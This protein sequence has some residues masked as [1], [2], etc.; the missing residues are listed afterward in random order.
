MSADN[1]QCSVCDKYY[2][3]VGERRGRAGHDD[4]TCAMCSERLATIALD[5]IGD[6]ELAKV[7]RWQIDYL[8]LALANERKERDADNLYAQRGY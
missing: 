1:W 8:R 6:Q 5:C 2:V 3:K 4:I 7:L